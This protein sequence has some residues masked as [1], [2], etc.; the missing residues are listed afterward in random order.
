MLTTSYELLQQNPK[1]TEEEVRQGISGVLC[2]CTG[3]KQIIDS[4]MAA[5]A[6]MRSKPRAD[7]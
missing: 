3:Y 1:P 5:A 4:V 7:K 2:R 6:E